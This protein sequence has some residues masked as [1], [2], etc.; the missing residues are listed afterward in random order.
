MNLNKITLGSIKFSN[1]WPISY[2]IE[3]LNPNV[4]CKY[5]APS[6]INSWLSDGSVDAGMISM[7]E[8][9]KNSDKYIILDE[10]SISSK[11]AVKSII[12]FSKKKIEHLDGCTVALPNTSASS[13]N[14]LKIL[15]A[16]YGYKVEYIMSPPNLDTMMERADA[17][18]L[19]GDDALYW[20]NYNSLLYQYDLGEEWYAQTGK[21]MVF[22]VGAIRR[23]FAINNLKI[24][25]Y[26]HD[27]YL[28]SKKTGISNMEIITKR[29]V[30]EIGN[31]LIY[32][33]DYFKGLYYDLS[34]EF[35]DGMKKFIE[36]AYKHG[37]LEQNV[38]LDFLS[39]YT[40]EIM[41]KG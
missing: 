36:M 20:R 11:G 16:E 23:D 14:L 31:D 27:L 32:W 19:I 22:A 35:T 9:A 10:L 15:L 17:A 28:N 25:N 38:E 26:I 8:Y 6:E 21:P 2:F 29:C 13:I 3:T 1:A 12:L 18:L 34:F 4:A 5:G 39:T 30:E 33:E 40:K 41:Y 7:F 37:F 24:A